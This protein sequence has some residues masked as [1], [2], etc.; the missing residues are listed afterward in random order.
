MNIYIRLFLLVSFCLFSSISF[1]EITSAEEK[2]LEKLSPD[3]RF[4]IM[5][6]MDKADSLQE[7]I[8]EVFEQQNTLIER[9]ELK[10]Q[11]DLDLCEKCIY[12]YDF[13]KYSPSTFA[14]INNIPISS[15][16]VLGP[17]DKIEVSYFGSHKEKSVGFISREGIFTLPLLGP[18]NLLGL[19]YTDA[20]DL[21]K[22]KIKSEL[23][24]AN[25]SITLMD[26]RSI[27]VY[28]LGQAYKPGSYTLGGLSTVTNALFVSG[29][30]NEF[31]SLRNIEVKRAGETIKVY[32]FYEFLLK[33]RTDSDIRLQNGDIIFVPYIKKRVKVGN[34]FKGPDL[35]EVKEG[36]TIRDMIEISGGFS[37]GVG[38]TEK[39]EYSSINYVT[40]KRSLSYLSQ[41][42]DNLDKQLN[43]GDVINISKNLS[44]LEF[45]S[46]EIAGEVNKP[47]EYSILKGDTILDLIDRAGGYSDD[48]FP[49][50]AI[51]LRKDVAKLQKEGFERSANALEEY[52]INLVSKG[53]TGAMPP[54]SL[55][56][57]SKVITN[58][59]NEVP[60][61]RQVVEVDYLQLKTDP[62]VN[63]IM[64]DG[65]Y[66]FIPK[67]PVS[68][69]ITGEVFN[70]S[71]QRYSSSLSLN[72][73]IELAGGLKDGADNDKIFIVLPSGESVVR[74][75]RLFSKNSSLLLP[76]STI[77]V[78]RATYS[79]MEIASLLSP[80]LAGFATSAASLAV[81]SQTS[82]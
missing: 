35:Y 5:E 79:G 43:D 41:N 60:L 14:P 2:M 11:V 80:V 81:L 62:R 3:Q 47:G 37:S 67:R 63:F 70:P 6:K 74:D 61:G 13:F 78:G 7:D 57:I 48:S 75:R 42:S 26:L 32:D 15:A 76:G 56:T 19:T 33:G 64:Q 77:V 28:L 46:V 12:G 18:V 25:V 17:G 31:G 44:L 21:I 20:I 65:D 66:F 24:G 71:V 82:R 54:E 36:E 30:V 52:M 68:I 72:Q 59:R 73:Y 22:R 50:G 51:F 34:G 23:T 16:Y 27:S 10:N 39:L 8:D 69:S 4:S 29:G 45:G 53:T 49:E 58:L 1:S 38:L 55:A 9:P 40:N